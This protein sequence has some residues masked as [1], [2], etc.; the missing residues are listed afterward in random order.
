MEAIKVRNVAVI[1]IINVG[2]ILKISG[3]KNYRFFNVL[4]VTVKQKKFSENNVQKL[5]ESKQQKRKFHLELAVHD[6][7]FTERHHNYTLSLSI[8]NSGVN[9]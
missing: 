3:I 2:Q 8:L 4:C 5:S 6:K 1:F 9:K 7:I